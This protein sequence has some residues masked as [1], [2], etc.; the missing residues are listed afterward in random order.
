MSYRCINPFLY[1]EDIFAGGVQVPDDHP[2][3]QTHAAFFA[4][5]DD[6]RVG[7]ETATL[8]P[9]E[10]RT[11]TPAASDQ[12]AAEAAA[13]Q[14]AEAQHE[15]DVQAWL[16]AEERYQ[17]DVAAWLIAEAEAKAEPAQEP[18]VSA[19]TEAPKPPRPQARRSGTKGTR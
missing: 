13:R 5:V 19:A 2:I 1:G 4:R 12:E 9:T 3:L 18:P 8:A 10:V 16:L 14:A 7:T 17:S 11:P 6:L 15:E